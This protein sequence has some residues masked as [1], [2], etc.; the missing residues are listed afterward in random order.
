MRRDVSNLSKI[1]KN[2]PKGLELYSPIIGSCE[3]LEVTDAVINIHHHVGNPPNYYYFLDSKGRLHQDGDCILFPSKTMRTWEMWEDALFTPGMILKHK[4]INKLCVYRGNNSFSYISGM[5]LSYNTY[6]SNYGF[7]FAS[8]EEIKD[9][10]AELNLIGYRWNSEINDFER[11]GEAYTPK[12]KKGDIVYNPTAIEDVMYKILAIEKSKDT[13]EMEYVVEILGVPVNPVRNYTCKMLDEWAEPQH[14]YN[15]GDYI[16]IVDTIKMI[17]SKDKKG[18]IVIDRD[19]KEGWYER[20]FIDDTSEKATINET[21][22]FIDQRREAFKKNTK[23]CKAEKAI[24]WLT[25]IPVILDKAGQKS[26]CDF[27]K[28]SKNCKFFNR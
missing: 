5:G 4:E 9:F 8:P 26:V 19:N 6:N 13:K 12:Y 11:I 27:C 18:Y 10:E 2:A 17:V 22:S 7:E 28:H 15:P 1:L 16:K 25:D 3:L 20:E 24:L 14:K 21:M 23:L